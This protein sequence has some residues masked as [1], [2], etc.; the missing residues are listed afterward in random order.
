MNHAETIRELASPIE[1]RATGREPRLDAFSEVEAVIFDIYGTLIISGAGDISLADESASTGAMR[2]ALEVAF[3]RG[4]GTSLEEIDL[5]EAVASYHGLIRSSQ[6]SMRAGGIDF[7][8]VE[9]RTIWRDL[10]AGLGAGDPTPDVIE[11][12]AVR[13]E[14]VANPVWPMPGLAEVL[15]E[16]KKRGLKL[17]IVSNAQFYTPW[18][19]PAFLGKGLDELGFDPDWLIFSFER[20]E[21]KPSRSLFAELRRRGVDPARAIYVG[22][23]RLKDIWPSG[24]EGFGT[25]LFAGDE[26]SLRWRDDDPRLEGVRPDA[27]ITHLDQLITLLP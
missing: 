15:A 7:P 5:D 14:C 26:R 18:M 21:G 25:V 1:P 19:F 8:E 16:L 23:D 22:N 3:R 12:A 6:E 27:E 2:A 4:E 24:L 17:G 13:F 20:R 11:E 9:I 10:L